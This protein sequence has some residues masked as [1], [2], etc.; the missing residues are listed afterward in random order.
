MD[1]DDPSAPLLLLDDRMLDDDAL[2]VEL[3]ERST[4]RSSRPSAAAAVSAFQPPPTAAD[5]S[6]EHR[7]MTICRQTVT[8]SGFLG[9][10]LALVSLFLFGSVAIYR[11]VMD[12]FPS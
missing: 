3:E 8:A 7:R 9:G 1:P 2:D 10:M 4:A 12:Q 6:R 11:I 5:Q